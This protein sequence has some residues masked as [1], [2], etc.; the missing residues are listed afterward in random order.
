MYLF[1]INVAIAVFCIVIADHSVLVWA[2][3]KVI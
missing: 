2:H 3:S 1:E